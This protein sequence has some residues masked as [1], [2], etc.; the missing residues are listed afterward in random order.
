MAAAVTVMEQVRDLMSDVFPACDIPAVC[1][2]PPGECSLDGETT[3]EHNEQ[4][5]QMGHTDP[6]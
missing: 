2:L 1:V 4:P 5:G 3:P 6:S